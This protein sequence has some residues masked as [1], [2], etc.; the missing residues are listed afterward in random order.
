MSPA[1]QAPP[2]VVVLPP[3][4]LE[5][6]IP[7]PMPAPSASAAPPAPAS[8]A[9]VRPRPE[10]DRAGVD[11]CAYLGGMGF[12]CLAALL[13]EKDPVARR[14]MRRMSDADARDA[15]DALA[16][17]EPGGVAHAE[18]AMFC[19]DAGPCGGTSPGGGVEDDGY[20]CLTKAEAA[21]Q[22]KDLARARTAHARACR[23]DA[24]RAQIP[25]M[26]GFLACDGPG[27]PVE[28]GKNLTTAEAADVRDC[29]VCDAEKGPAACARE[30]R[31]LET[32]DAELARYIETVHVARCR[33]P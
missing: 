14:Y 28:R 15:I 25:V 13:E 24:A 32:P 17:G 27:R 10:S 26:G 21:R 3:P 9:F 19:K 18:V 8:T 29:A 23:C 5:S 30:I 1:P 7:I 33:K 4:P 12:A 2:A 22:Q 31:R 20:A 16:R 6:A 11:A